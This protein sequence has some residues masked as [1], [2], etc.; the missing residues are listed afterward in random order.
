MPSFNKTMSQ[1]RYESLKK[2]NDT[3]ATTGA[4]DGNAHNE[5]EMSALARKRLADYFDWLIE[6]H[7]QLKRNHKRGEETHGENIDRLLQLRP[8]GTTNNPERNPGTKT[9]S[10]VQQ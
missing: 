5:N 7:V 10:E 2:S 3:P 4:I 8:M 1:S 9:N 6:A